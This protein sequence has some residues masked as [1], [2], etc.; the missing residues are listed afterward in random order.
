MLSHIYVQ[1]IFPTIIFLSRDNTILRKG[2][3]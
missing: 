3:Y 2:R 1:Y